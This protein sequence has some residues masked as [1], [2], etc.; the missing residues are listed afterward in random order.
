MF[1]VLHYLIKVALRHY[2]ML[3]R[4][5]IH[6]ALKLSRT[7]LSSCRL[8]ASPLRMQ[9]CSLAIMHQKRTFC[10][11]FVVKKHHEDGRGI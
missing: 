6:S 2:L 9:G 5:E 4:F 10:C 8:A 7:T 3:H 1:S 11:P